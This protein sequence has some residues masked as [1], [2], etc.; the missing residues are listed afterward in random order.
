[1]CIGLFLALGALFAA[2]PLWVRTT[3]LVDLH[4]ARRAIARADLN[5]AHEWLRAAQGR[6]PDNA[7]L[8]YLLAR[9]Y[10]RGALYL[11]AKEHLQSAEDLGWPKDDLELQRTMLH[12]QLGDIREAELTALLARG[13]DDELAEEVYDALMTGYMAEYRMQDAERCLDHWLAWQ[14]RSVAARIWRANHLQALLRNEEYQAALRD[15]L[16]IDPGRVDQ[17]LALAQWLTKEARVDEALVELAICVKQ[18]PD[19]ARVRLA[20]GL[21]HYKQGAIDDARRELEESVSRSL[22]AGDEARARTTLGQIALDAGD[23]ELAARH[24]ERAVEL[25]PESSVAPYGLGTALSRMGQVERGRLY[26]Q[27]SQELHD[28]EWRL[29]DVGPELLKDPGNTALRLEAAN[30]LLDIGDKASAAKYML[31]ALQ[32][33]PD[34]S[35]A[36]EMLADFFQEQGR[37]DLAREHR[38]H[39]RPAEE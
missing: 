11:R 31:S 10:R 37:T 7:E 2:R 5:R 6:Q 15:V 8:H 34:L 3:V 24:F 25:A 33:D 19:D 4:Q 22:D 35:E 32:Y 16:S 36:H 12:F 38:R 23:Y 29:Q 30:I 26:L 39:A 18:A 14:P 27:R 21:C 1:M 28:L 9:V 13:V 20:L 17:R